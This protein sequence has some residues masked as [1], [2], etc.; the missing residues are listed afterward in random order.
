MKT[1]SPFLSVAAAVVAAACFAVTA[2][3]QAPQTQPSAPPPGGA[4]GA[5]HGERHFPPPKNLQVLP[6][7]LT[8]EQVHHIMEGWAQ[9]LGTHCD[10]CHAPDPKA[11]VA[12]GH[13][14]RLDF[15]LDIKPDKST[16]RLMYKMVQDINTNYIAMVK[17]SGE[18][19]DVQSSEE[20]HTNE[21]VSCAT[22]HR[23]HLKPPA[24]VPPPEHRE[25][26]G[27]QGA[28]TGVPAARPTTGD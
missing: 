19:A 26:P 10:T 16:A 11:V 15:P 7:D 17:E 14:P 27:P 23:G 3:A 25:G 12:A 5:P 13:R 6:K 21:K 8:G 18:N 1:A 2:V 24:F 9:S 4:M 28:P 22:C 20:A